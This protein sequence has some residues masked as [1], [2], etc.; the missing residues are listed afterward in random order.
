VKRWEKEGIKIGTVNIR[1]LTMLKMFLLGD[2]E[3]I[4]VLCAQETWME[5]GAL[6]PSIPGYKVVE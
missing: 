6:M 2:I 4:D 3:N 5:Y 1:G